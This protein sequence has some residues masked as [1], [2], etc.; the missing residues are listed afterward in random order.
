M[1]SFKNWVTEHWVEVLGYMPRCTMAIRWLGIILKA[2]EDVTRLLNGVCGIRP[3]CGYV[4][5]H[6]LFDA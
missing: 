6:P 3:L 4:V 1:P 5:G 2:S